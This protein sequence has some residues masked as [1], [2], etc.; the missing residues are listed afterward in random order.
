MLVALAI[1][2]FVGEE[3]DAIVIGAILVLNA[4]M[5]FIQEYKA[6]KAIEHAERLQI[7]ES[8]SKKEIKDVSQRLVK[9][10]SAHDPFWPR[11]TYYAEEH[12]VE[13]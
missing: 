9:Y 8:A 11:W 10:L 6:E 13:L 4:V 7:D 12:G 1:S 5:G 2:I 3:I